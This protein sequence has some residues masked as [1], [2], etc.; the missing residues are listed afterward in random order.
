METTL[1]VECKFLSCDTNRIQFSFRCY[2]IKIICCPI[3]YKYSLG[4][5]P[6]QHSS[7][8]RQHCGTIRNMYTETYKLLFAYHCVRCTA[9]NR[10]ANSQG[11]PEIAQGIPAQ[12]HT[13]AVSLHNRPRFTV[14][15]NTIQMRSYKEKLRKFLYRS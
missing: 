4:G 3:R 13:A 12:E 11:A 10:K 14:V 8:R 5:L 15:H 1:K 2:L 9:L 7:E 6:L